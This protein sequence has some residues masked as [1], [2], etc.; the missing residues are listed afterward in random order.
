MY[1]LPQAGKLAYN[2]LVR[3]L[4]PHVYAPCRHTPGLWRQKR[5]PIL[6]SLVV[7]DFGVKY[8]GRAHAEHLVTTLRKYHTLKTYW[9]G[10]LYCGIKLK[11]DYTCRTVDLSIPGYIKVVSL[12]YQHPEPRKLQHAPHRWDKPQYV[13]TTQ[14]A[15]PVDKTPKLD[16]EGIKHIQKVIGTLLYYA[17][18]IDST[19]LMEI[20]AISSPK[21]Q[22]Q[23]P[24]RMP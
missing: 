2:Q 13:Q 21:Q 3:K 7:N 18:P 19:M 17:H 12:K 6:F 4:E 11:W 22:A 5:R 16:N 8:V 15:K 14:Y 9:A 23:P 20:N 10:T 24:P 1:G